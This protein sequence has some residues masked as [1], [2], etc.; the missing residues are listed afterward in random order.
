[1]TK[2]PEIVTCWIPVQPPSFN[3]STSIAPYLDG[4]VEQ[5]ISPSGKS[6]LRPCPLEAPLQ[7]DELLLDEASVEAGEDDDAAADE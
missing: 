6:W 4:K 1:V 5:S 3:Q 7:L 2:P